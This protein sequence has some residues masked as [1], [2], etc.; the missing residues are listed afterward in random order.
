MLQNVLQQSERYYSENNTYTTNLTDL[1]YPAGSVYS[2]HSTHTITL[3]RRSHRRHRH[4]RDGHGHAGCRRRQVQCDL[5]V[6]HQ[7]PQRHGNAA[8]HL[9]VSAGPC[10]SDQRRIQ[11]R[12]GEQVAQRL[13]A[14]QAGTARRSRSARTPWRTT[15]GRPTHQPSRA[16]AH[17]WRNRAQ[18]DVRRPA[19]WRSVPRWR[20]APRW[21]PNAAGPKSSRD[22]RVAIGHH[23]RPCA[24]ARRQ[25]RP[26]AVPA[27]QTADSTV[28]TGSR[29]PP[30]TRA[31]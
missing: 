8:V 16:A 7:C 28:I 21:P 24:C 23:P 30:V 12:H 29:I 10:G 11:S 9:L 22:V 6:Q 4:Q 15:T 3:G 5:A 26:P 2:E 31:A 1:G 13:P 18:R 20:S 17:H 27:N 19:A 14:R 25:C